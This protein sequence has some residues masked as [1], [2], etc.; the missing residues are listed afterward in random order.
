MSDILV[1]NAGSSSIKFSI[2][3]MGGD[4]CNL[5]F[6]LRGE[7]EGIGAEHARFRA[8]S[9]AGHVLLEKALSGPD[10]HLNHNQALA[11]LMQWIEDREAQRPII[12]AGHR[13]VHGG[14][15]VATPVHVNHGDLQQL[16]A[17]IQLVPVS[18][19]DNLAD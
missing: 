10:T 14:V 13:V 8:A 5:N 7:I 4:E 18:L 17:R 11:E 3:M 1:L 19:H 15:H 6:T 9:A 16:D 2:F 12:A